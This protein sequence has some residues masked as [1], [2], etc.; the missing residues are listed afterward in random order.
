M[1]ATAIEDDLR[2]KEH[3]N[4]KWYSTYPSWWIRWLVGAVVCG[5]LMYTFVLG[6]GMDPT[7][8]DD[9]FRSFFTMPISIGSFTCDAV[10]FVAGM[11]ANR[12]E[13]LKNP[14]H[15]S[16]WRRMTVLVAAVLVALIGFLLSGRLGSL[17]IVPLFW[18]LSGIYCTEMSTFILSFFQKVADQPPTQ[19]GK[20]LSQA[21][22]TVYLLH[23]LVYT[24]VLSAFV[25]AYNAIYG[26]V[27]QFDNG[28]TA[29]SSPLLGP[30]NGSIALLAGWLT[31]NFVTHLLVWPLSYWIQKLPVLNQIL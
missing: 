14:I 5:L 22:Y 9:A 16:W 20:F 21:A 4:N 2:N 28:T 7:L 6:L 23:P 17:E 26:D 8:P 29:S 30:A 19:F 31:V 3:S 18:L 25:I 27:I 12:Y 15:S 1:G 24:A 10:F 11:A 13:W